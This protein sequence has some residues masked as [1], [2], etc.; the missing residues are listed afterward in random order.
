MST[1]GRDLRERRS[2]DRG[3]D[4]LQQQSR[5][6]RAGVALRRGRLRA[7]GPVHRR[8]R[9][10]PD[11]HGRLRRL[12]A[13]GD[14]AARAR[15]RA[16]DVRPPL[17]AREQPRDRRRSAR[18]CRTAR[19]SAGLPREMGFDEPCFRES[20]DE[21]AAA[22]F[23]RAELRLG[24][25]EAQR[26][27]KARPPED[28]C[29]VRERRLSDEERQVRDLL[30]G[31]RGARPRSAAGLRRRRTRSPMRRSPHAFRSR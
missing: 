29:A 20:D 26:L 13:A 17:Y 28:L 11:R 12:R 9:A 6:R 8:A 25:L 31:A 23:T 30:G 21:I 19:S 5:R 15:R 4:R 14:D 3:T 1:I 24:S 16:Q 2:A 10:V 18:R 27:A 7:R 22:A